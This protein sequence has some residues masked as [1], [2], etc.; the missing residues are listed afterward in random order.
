MTN[1]VSV[2]A[3]PPGCPVPPS[4]ELHDTP[5]IPGHKCVNR[6]IGLDDNSRI[7]LSGLEPGNVPQNAGKSFPSPSAPPQARWPQIPRSEDKEGP[8][9][10]GGEDDALLRDRTD[11]RMLMT[12]TQSAGSD[13]WG[14]TSWRRRVN[15]LR[16]LTPALLLSRC[17]GNLH[18]VC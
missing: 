9:A 10:L 8:G 13:P 15:A 4:A 2:T 6:P 5:S 11:A 18:R 12:S 3:A 1:S 16:V 17:A 7:G 14:G